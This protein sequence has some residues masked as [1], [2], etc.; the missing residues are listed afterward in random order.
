M[1][2]PNGAMKL[3][4]PT[5]TLHTVAET[6]ASNLKGFWVE[7]NFNKGQCSSSTCNEENKENEVTESHTWNHLLET[8]RIARRRLQHHMGIDPKNPD[9]SWL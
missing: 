5:A 4:T 1:Y 3:H 2:F 6:K 9:F 7:N 8:M